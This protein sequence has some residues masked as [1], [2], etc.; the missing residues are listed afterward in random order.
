[1]A[2][3][4]PAVYFFIMAQPP[5][6]LTPKGRGVA[7]AVKVV[8]GSS[9]QGVAGRYGEGI[10]V[11]VTSKPV[12]GAANK[13]VVELLAEILQVPAGHIQIIRGKT[14]PRKEVLIM[15]LPAEVIARRLFP[16]PS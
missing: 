6:S 5:L 14:H 16:D 13:A 2:D 4:A 3:A 7:L 15:G 11:T 12:D 10:K 1:M 8:P 9:R